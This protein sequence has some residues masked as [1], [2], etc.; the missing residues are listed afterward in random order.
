MG[1]DGL[2][3]AARG[4]LCLEQIREGIQTHQ[5]HLQKGR[6]RQVGFSRF[7]DYCARRILCFFDGWCGPPRDAFLFFYK[8]MERIKGVQVPAFLSMFSIF[9]GDHLFA[10]FRFLEELIF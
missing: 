6:F 8:A 3:Y 7:C 4:Q 9:S 1:C 2:R 10:I 5:Q